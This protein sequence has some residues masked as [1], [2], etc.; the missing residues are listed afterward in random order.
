MN[1]VYFATGQ[2]SAE[3]AELA[4]EAL[5]ITNPGARPWVLT[6]MHTQFRTL[7]PFRMHCSQKTM[8]FDRTILQFNFLREHGHALFL[9]SDCVVNKPLQGMFAGPLAVTKRKPPKAVPEQI[10]NGGVLYG[11]GK[12][13]LR[14][15][16]SWV[17][18][19]QQIDRGAWEWWGDQMILPVIVPHFQVKVYES[20]THNFIPT[21]INLPFDELP[22]N[23]VHFKGE[24]RKPWMPLYVDMLRERH[25]SLAAA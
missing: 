8:I 17:D 24:K 7:E 13:A 20:E 1:V 11:E 19:Y 22:A 2:K 12:E 3:Q 5:R 23:I 14:F 18:T 4:A 25:A 21:K 15:W 9:D 10:Y 6:D 16:Q